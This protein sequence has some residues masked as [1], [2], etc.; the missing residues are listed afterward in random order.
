MPRISTDSDIANKIENPISVKGLLEVL[1]DY[2]VLRQDS[3]S[4]SSLPKDVYIS[5]SQIRR[6]DLRMGDERKRS[7]T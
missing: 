5:Q 2:G 6:F 7:G 3:S 1:P 4:D